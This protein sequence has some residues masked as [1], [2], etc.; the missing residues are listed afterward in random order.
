MRLG[1]AGTL[2]LAAWQAKDDELLLSR[3]KPIRSIGSFGLEKSWT[4]AVDSRRKTTDFML[5]RSADGGM[6]TIN[7]GYSTNSE[8][9]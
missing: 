8:I 6:S 9:C 1:L 5:R 7:Q 4:A 3:N 2:L